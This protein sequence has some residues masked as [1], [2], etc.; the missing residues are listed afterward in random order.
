[1]ISHDAVG[2]Q[3]THLNIFYEMFKPTVEEVVLN[4]SIIVM[5]NF[6]YLVI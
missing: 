5:N 6:Y 4:T 1:M 2:G 3:V